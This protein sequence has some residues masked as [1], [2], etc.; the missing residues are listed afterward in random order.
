MSRGRKTEGYGKGMC[1]RCLE[2]SEMVKPGVGLRLH[3]SHYHTWC[4]PVARNCPG[5]ILPRSEGGKG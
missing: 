1:R 4:E 2:S 3:C 5:P